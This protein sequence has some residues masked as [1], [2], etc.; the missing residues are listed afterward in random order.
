MKSDVNSQIESLHHEIR[1]SHLPGK[2]RKQ[3]SHHR[4]NKL[5]N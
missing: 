3:I 2:E 5:K 1:T 4:A